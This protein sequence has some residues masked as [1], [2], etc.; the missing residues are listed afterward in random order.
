MKTLHLLSPLFFSCLLLASAGC[1][2]EEA[3]SGSARVTE[4]PEDFREEP[5]DVYFQLNKERE[6]AG[7]RH[8]VFQKSLGLSAKARADKIAGSNEPLVPDPNFDTRAKMM[9]YNGKV[10]LE[11]VLT[12][13]WRP[14]RATE[15]FLSDATRRRTILSSKVDDIGIAYRDQVWVMVL[16]DRD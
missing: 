8:F 15:E 12:G 11:T 13:D 3:V 10:E 5:C 1:G 14:E 7:L 2:E 9:G 6:I 16:G 4:C